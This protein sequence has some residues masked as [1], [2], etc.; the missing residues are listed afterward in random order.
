MFCWVGHGNGIEILR[1]VD[2]K[3]NIFNKLGLK[4]LSTYI[5]ERWVKSEK[6]WS[7]KT[8]VEDPLGKRVLPKPL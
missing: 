6:A 2:K 5:L 7:F 3:T 8:R 4:M 1:N